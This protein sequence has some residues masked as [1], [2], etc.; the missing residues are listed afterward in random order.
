MGVSEMT[1]FGME[2]DDFRTLAELM[3][4]VVIKDDVVTDQVKALREQF[5]E[6]QFC[7]R[8]VEYA[9]MMQKLHELL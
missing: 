1:R 7:F 3:R 5:R 4:D 6:L 2:E 8:G 9:G